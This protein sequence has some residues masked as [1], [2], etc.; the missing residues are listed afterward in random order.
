[1][2]EA[3]STKTYWLYFIL[4]LA[5]TAAFLIFLPEWCWVPLPFLFTALVKGFDWL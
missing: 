1:M 4:S 5:A 2:A 3:T